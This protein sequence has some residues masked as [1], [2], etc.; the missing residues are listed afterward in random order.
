ML[1]QCDL[2]NTGIKIT[3]VAVWRFSLTEVM[4]LKNYVC[5]SRSL[6]DKHL[7]CTLDMP[8]IIISRRQR[9]MPPKCHF[10]TPLNE[11]RDISVFVLLSI[12]IYD[13]NCLFVQESARQAL[14]MYR[15]PSRNVDKV[16]EV[17]TVLAD[18]SSNGF[19][20]PAMSTT[21]A[22]GRFNITVG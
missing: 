11:V 22:P 12:S 7:Q 18:R 14:A 16:W 6:L 3:Q 8:E 21:A 19:S 1:V 20:H 9:I 13:C 4:H 2:L 10:L 17:A 5:V 15:Y